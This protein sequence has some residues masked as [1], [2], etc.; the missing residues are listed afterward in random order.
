MEKQY[1]IIP[2]FLIASLSLSGQ[3]FNT[4]FQIG[5]SLVQANQY[6]TAIDQYNAAKRCPEMSGAQLRKVD[7]ALEAV[8]PT[9]LSRWLRMKAREA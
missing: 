6:E 3:C 1:Y 8:D 2:I 7:A 4:F 9:T 5:D